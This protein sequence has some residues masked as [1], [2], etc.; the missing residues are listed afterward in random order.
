MKYAWIKEHADSYEIKR[1]CKILEV[2]RSA[3]YAWLSRPPSATRVRQ[4]RIAEAASEAFEENHGEAGYRPIHAQLNEEGTECGREMVRKA[5][6]KQGLA[7]K[8][9]PKFVPQTTDSDHELPIAPNLL[10]REFTAS[11]PNEKW[12]SDIT[13]IRTGEGW[14]YL[15]V[16]IDLFSRKI[17]GWSMAEHMRSELVLEALDMAI[18]HRRP[19]ADLMF[20]SDRGSQYASKIFRKRLKFLKIT[21]SMSRKGN[22]WDNAP[23]ESFF[24]KL[25]TGWV[26]RQSYKTREEAVHSIY[27]FIEMYYNSKRRHATLGYVSPNDFERRHLAHAS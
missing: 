14:L 24:G 3:Y 4:Q 16:V 26:H 6:K 8:I 21:Q 13:Y 18:V 12:T 10:D 5:L 9:A 25:K 11:R 2:C 17:V 20:H 23:S 27:F 15:A 7:A 1:M 19:T 22:C